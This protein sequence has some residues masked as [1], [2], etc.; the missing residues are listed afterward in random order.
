MNQS[1]KKCRT[2][3]KASVY[4]DK[5]ERKTGEAFSVPRLRFDGGQAIDAMI[6]KT[7]TA[8]LASERITN[9]TA[10]I[11]NAGGAGAGTDI[12]S[13]SDEMNPDASNAHLK[14]TVFQT[15][16]THK[17]FQFLVKGLQSREPIVMEPFQVTTADLKAEFYCLG[18]PIYL[19]ISRNAYGRMLRYVDVVYKCSA[20]VYYRD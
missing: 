1:D 5:G 12:E 7:I 3:V 4:V 8:I 19:R 6:R 11:G 15:Q 16:S 20:F 18:G 17:I 10:A 9:A 14:Y 13:T 2:I